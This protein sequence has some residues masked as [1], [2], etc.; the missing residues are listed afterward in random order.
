MGGWRKRE[1]LAR[2]VKKMESENCQ[3]TAENVM[4][5]GERSSYLCWGRSRMKIWQRWQHG[6]YKQNCFVLRPASAKSTEL[7]TI[8]YIWR[9]ERAEDSRAVPGLPKTVMG[10]DGRSP[11]EER[12]AEPIF[13]V[14]CVSDRGLRNR[15]L[16]RSSEPAITM[17][18]TVGK[19]RV[20]TNYKL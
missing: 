16:P 6:K 1:A 7:K 20:C 9:N 2:A 14:H 12:S 8:L 10:S 4:Q 19:R 17:I 11:R 15:S 3:Q 13:H 5:W 18:I